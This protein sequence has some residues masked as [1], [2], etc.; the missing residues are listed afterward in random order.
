MIYP[1]PRTYIGIR[2]IKRHRPIRDRADNIILKIRPSVLNT[3]VLTSM[4]VW[5]KM[6]VNMDVKTF[7]VASNA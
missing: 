4:N 7:L 6:I 3:R 1:K 5:K 2:P